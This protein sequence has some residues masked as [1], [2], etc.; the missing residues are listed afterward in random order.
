MTL[1]FRWHPDEVPPE[2][3]AH[4]KAKLNVLRHYLRAYF[5]TLN[6]MPA[7]DNFKLDLIDGFSGGGI[8][9]DNGETIPGTPLI[10]LEET[11]D[12][13]IRLNQNRRKPLTST[14][15]FTS[16]TKK[17]LTLIILI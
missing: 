5:D 12:A 14:A 3:Q 17:K 8:F 2:I 1:S 15:S 4:S 7:R 16:L 13:E 10:M 9:S 6:V 11:R